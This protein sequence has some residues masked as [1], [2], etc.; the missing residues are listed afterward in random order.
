MQPS[1]PVGSATQTQEGQ[2]SF[3]L[4]V[5]LG[6]AL[7]LSQK[8][9]LVASEARI[10]TRAYLLGASLGLTERL[11]LS[12]G[13]SLL[14]VLFSGEEKRVFGVGAAQVAAQYS[15]LKPAPQKPSLLAGLSFSLPGGGVPQPDIPAASVS[16]GSYDPTFSLSG[17]VP[18][19]PVVFLAEAGVRPQIVPIGEFGRLPGALARA[20]LGLRLPDRLGSLETRLEGLWRGADEGPRGLEENTGGAWLYVASSARVAPPA[21]RGMACFAEVRVPVLQKLNGEQLADGI[22]GFFGASYRLPVF[23]PALRHDETEEAEEHHEGDGHDHGHEHG[24]SAAPPSAEEIA[25]LDIQQAVTDGRFVDPASL[26]VPGK[27]TL[28]HYGA[29]WCHPCHEL[30]AQTV[31]MM[32]HDFPQIALREVDIIDWEKPLALRYLSRLTDRIPYVE[33]YDTE[34]HLVR[35]IVSDM[36]A[37]KATVQALSR[38]KTP[39]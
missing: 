28:V 6:E 37:I 38:E 22:G 12:G 10:Y 4:R 8:G 16:A 30:R 36:E 19:G 29:E 33:I 31:E 20:S 23:G 35:G 24:D 32:A 34:G 11:G 15:L 3:D 39:F 21:L 25:A 14:D 27:I 5:A 7:G 26:A 18:A 9:E 13:L 2:L 17:S 1:L